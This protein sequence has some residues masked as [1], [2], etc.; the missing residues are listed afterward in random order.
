MRRLLAHARGRRRALTIAVL[1]VLTA[2]VVVVVFQPQRL[3]YDTTVRET[4]PRGAS[5]VGGATALRFGTFRGLAHAASGRALLLTFADGSRV[6]R[7]EDLDVENGPDLHVYLAAAAADRPASAFGR[8]H[9]ELGVLRGNRGDQNYP[10]PRDVDTDRFRTAVIWSE[11]FS[12]GFA[13][14]PLRRS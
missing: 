4:A 9:V 7:L 12:V 2:A 13:V 10:V 14:A 5:G 6:L 11:R 8:N 3:V 1:A